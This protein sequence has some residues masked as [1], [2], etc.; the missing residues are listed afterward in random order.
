M[1]HA[2]FSQLSLQ[3]ETPEDKAFSDQNKVYGCVL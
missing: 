2:E 3:L 1:Q